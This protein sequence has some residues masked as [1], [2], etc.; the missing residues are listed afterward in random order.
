MIIGPMTE[1]EMNKLL[2][3]FEDEVDEVYKKLDIL[4]ENK[5]EW[6]RTYGAFL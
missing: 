3:F 6:G 5:D 1:E 2:D 4:D